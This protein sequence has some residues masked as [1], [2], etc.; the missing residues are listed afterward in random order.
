MII[1]TGRHL[2]NEGPGLTLTRPGWPRAK[3]TQGQGQL[4]MAWPSRVRVRASKKVPGPGPARPLDSVGGPSSSVVARPGHPPINP[5]RCNVLV[6]LLHITLSALLLV[7][8]SPVQSG[9]LPIFGKTETE[10]GL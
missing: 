7:L 10:T 6:L 1:Y 2:S 9:L 8:E 5:A 4:K 3:L